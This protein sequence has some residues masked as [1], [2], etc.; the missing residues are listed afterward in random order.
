MN[1]Q[2]AQTN[3]ALEEDA[4]IV[5]KNQGK[6]AGPTG[7]VSE[8]LKAA[9]ETGTLKMTDVCNAGT[10]NGKFSREFEQELDGECLQRNR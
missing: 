2:N 10:R 1:F 5:K 3:S 9:G 8:M 7:V 4:A 6:S